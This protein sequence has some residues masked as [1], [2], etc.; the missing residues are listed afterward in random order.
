MMIQKRVVF[1]KDAAE[2][3]IFT[4]CFN[5][6]ADTLALTVKGSGLFFIEGRNGEDWFSLAAINLTN[7]S[8]SKDGIIESGIYEI[9]I[10]SIRELRCRIEKVT[11][12]A[13]IEGELINSLEI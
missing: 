9:G 10:L 4:S 13:T 6:S 1:C 12:S 5:T 7:F 11:E 8:I 2:A 3:G